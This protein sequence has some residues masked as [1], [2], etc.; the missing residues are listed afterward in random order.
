MTSEFSG[1]F[2]KEEEVFGAIDALVRGD[3]GILARDRDGGVTKGIVVNAGYQDGSV[4][5][6]P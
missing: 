3:L 1:P 6:H 2:E 5:K 4:R